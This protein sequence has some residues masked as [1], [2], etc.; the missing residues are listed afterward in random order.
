LGETGCQAG[1]IQFFNFELASGINGA[2]EINPNSIV[3]T[4]GGTALF[5]TFTFTLN[6]QAAAA[7]IL[8]SFFRFNVT[9]PGIT[10][11]FI[12]LNSPSATG[13]AAVTGILDVCS[14]AKF[15]GI[16]PIGCTGQ[17]STAIA[18]AI[19]DDSQ[20]IDRVRSMPAGFFDVFVDLTI[21]GGLSGSAALPSAT[22][23]F[24]VPEASSGLLWALGAISLGLFRRRAR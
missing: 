13:G 24:A 18:F 15:A 4:P 11:G 3:V 8:E 2:T 6:A 9:G 14:G 12:R 16:V 23:G 5:P 7:Q 20:L 21:D 19:A 1:S 10:D 17:P 22:V